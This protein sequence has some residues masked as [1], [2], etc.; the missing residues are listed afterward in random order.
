MEPFAI[1]AVHL[2][3]AEA[4]SALPDA[5]VVPDRPSTLSR[6]AGAAAAVRR[7]VFGRHLRDAAVSPTRRDVRR[8]A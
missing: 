8:A 5:P 7:G 4:R 1:V 6:M 3:S 2:I